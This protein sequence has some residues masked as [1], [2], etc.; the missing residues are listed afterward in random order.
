MQTNPIRLGLLF[1]LFLAL[2]H[3]AWA[4]LVATG[5][6]Q[7]VLDFVFWAHFIS[8]PYH[9]DAFDLARAAILVGLTFT[10]GLV[11]GIV[12]GIL[13]NRLARSA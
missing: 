3:A 12:A 2:F 6:A 9:V 10:V 8:P 1:G 11:M 5:W 4:T 13:W 7:A